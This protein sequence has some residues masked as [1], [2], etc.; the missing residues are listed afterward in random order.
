MPIPIDAAGAGTMPLPVPNDPNLSSRSFHLQLANLY[1]TLACP[2]MLGPT[3]GV[4]ASQ[5]LT[6]T[7][8]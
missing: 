7:I 2:C 4:A 1:V 5:G 3:L 6:I 8:Q